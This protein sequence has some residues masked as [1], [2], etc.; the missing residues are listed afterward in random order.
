MLVVNQIKGTYEAKETHIK[1]YWDRTN[2]ALKSFDSFNITQVPRAK[3]KKAD[4]LSKLAS[5]VFSHLTKEVLVEILPRRSIETKRI[6]VLDIH[7]EVASWMSPFVLYLR[8]GILPADRGEARKV[9]INAGKYVIINETLYRK[10]YS[11]PWLRCVTPEEGAKIIEDVHTGTCGAHTGS[12]AVTH[13]VLRAGYFWPTMTTDTQDI[14]KKC[15]SCQ[16]HSNVPTVPQVELTSIVAPWPFFRWGIDIVVPFP[17]A[18]GKVKFLVVAIDYFTK[19]VE[20]EPLATISGEK[21]CKFV[22]KQIVCRFG[23]PHTIVSDNGKQL[24]ENPFKK[25]CEE[26]SIRQSFTTVAHPQANGQTEVTNR[27]IVNG[28]KT[29]LENSTKSWVDELQSVL[30]AYRTTARR[31]TGDTPYSL[32]YG[33]EAVIPIELS[34]PS[35]R[36]AF[37]APLTNDRDLRTNLDLVDE[38][39]RN[40]EI[41]QAV[42]KAAVEQ[43]YNKRVKGTACRVGEL[44]LRRNEASRQ[45]PTRKLGPKWEGPYRV[46]EARRN[47]SYMLETMQGKRLPRPWNITNLRRF[48][49]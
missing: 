25:W 17:E 4:A 24:A 31:A 49:F 11:T 34:I 2:Q 44:V 3:N 36:V 39:R 10:G 27:T 30:W 32:V 12:L 48:H 28:L 5:V 26:R 15:R 16:V 40:A 35:A 41:R 1:K 20:A 45:E 47:G 33:S 22:W 29:R 13:K 46:T 8:E 43:H 42:Y 9:R 6:E 37:T 14:I 18:P 21:I 38:L 23:L 7:E 19:W